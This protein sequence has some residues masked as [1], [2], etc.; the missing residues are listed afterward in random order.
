MELFIFARFHAK[1]GQEG[2]IAAALAEIM[3]P[4]NRE[5]GCRG[6]T[7]FRATGDPR[8][9]FIHSRWQDAAAFAHH[10]TLAHTIKFLETVEPLIDHPFDIVR[11]HRLAGAS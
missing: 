1:A 4:T 11:T 2:A 9:F 6:A 3:I 7:T 10:A 8:L 5:P